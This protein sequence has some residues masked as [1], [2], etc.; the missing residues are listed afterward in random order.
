[1]RRHGLTAAMYIDGA[2]VTAD[3]RTTGTPTDL[4]SGSSL[5][6]GNSVIATTYDLVTTG[7]FDDVRIYNSA[8]ADCD[9]AL[10][11]TRP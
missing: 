5:R 7:T 6:L 2:L 10:V 8:L 11:G 9:V 4:S 1:M 3:T